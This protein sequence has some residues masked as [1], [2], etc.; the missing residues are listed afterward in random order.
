[1]PGNSLVSLEIS[2][3]CFL[4]YKMSVKLV[5]AELEV[6]VKLRDFSFWWPW[7]GMYKVLEM[8]CCIVG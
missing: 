7:H 3:V 2:Q 6:S 1:M 5:N 8:V 4:F